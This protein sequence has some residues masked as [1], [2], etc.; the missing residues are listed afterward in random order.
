MRER[1]VCIEI[2]GF[3]MHTFVRFS[4]FSISVLAVSDLFFALLLLLPANHEFIFSF[5]ASQFRK[6]RAE[7]IVYVKC[8]QSVSGRVKCIQQ[9]FGVCQKIIVRHRVH[10]R[11]AVFRF[12]LQRPNTLGFL[13]LGHAVASLVVAYLVFFGKFPKLPHLKQQRFHFVKF[14]G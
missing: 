6:Q 1:Q 11:L 12:R 14:H 5:F 13:T 9:V 7:F 8:I 4:L 2:A 3:V 10:N